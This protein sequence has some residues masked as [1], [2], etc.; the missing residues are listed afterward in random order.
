MQGPTF[1]NNLL[2]KC[3]G[4]KIVTRPHQYI[5]IIRVSNTERKQ[6]TLQR[7]IKS[8]KVMCPVCLTNKH[9]KLGHTVLLIE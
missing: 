6:T 1:L 4:Q 3:K 7:T 8:L 5:P 9:Q 2:W